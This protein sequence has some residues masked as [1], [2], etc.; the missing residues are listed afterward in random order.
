[1]KT[2]LTIDMISVT[3][4]RKRILPIILLII[5]TISCDSEN[6]NNCL[7]TDGD[8]ITYEEIV[9]AFSRIQ[10]END[11]QVI[12]KEGPEQEV[13]IETGENLVSDLT[14]KVEQETLILQNNNGCNFLR[15]FG[16]TI[17]RITSPNITFVRQASSFPI[18][19][20]GILSYPNLT[21]WSNTNPNSLNIDDPNKSGEVQLNLNVENLSIQANGSSNFILTGTSNMA[22]IIFSDEFPQMNAPNLLVQDLTIR[23]VSAAQMIVHPIN[24]ISGEIRATGD[25][26]AVNRP[27]TIDVETFFTGSLIFE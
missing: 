7:Q 25:V 20:D 9:P 1:M 12:L 27:P 10:L 8:T 14:I 19:S 18:V 15:E 24:S 23:H 17:V 2:F 6:A 13:L 26:I 16:K 3:L 11:I 21:I 5:A 4:S 22:T